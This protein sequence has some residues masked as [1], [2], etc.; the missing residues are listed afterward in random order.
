MSLGKDRTSLARNHDHIGPYSKI[1]RRGSLSRSIDGRSELGRFVRA[2]EAELVTHCGGS[3]S[4]TQRLLI[5][6]IIKV[7]L[8][9]DALD[10]KLAAGDWTPHDQ[11]TYGALLNAHRLACRELSLQPAQAP[12]PTLAEILAADRGA[13]A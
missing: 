8:Q 5:D 3:P 10:V 7:R 9:L 11:R 13:A 2:L 12:T 1:L 4:I 6:R